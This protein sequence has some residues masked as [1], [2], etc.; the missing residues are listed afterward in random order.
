MAHLFSSYLF[1]LSYILYFEKYK[2]AKKKSAA[3]EFL[4]SRAA[5]SF[6]FAVFF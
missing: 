4:H 6:G 2:F 5:D 3:R 1:I